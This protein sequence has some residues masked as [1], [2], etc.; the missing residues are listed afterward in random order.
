M[1]RRL[2]AICVRL[3][4]VNAELE[5][6]KGERD[7]LRLEKLERGAEARMAFEAEAERFAAALVNAGRAQPARQRQ[8]RELYF[9]DKELALEAASALEVRFEAGATAG[10]PQE[11]GRP[12]ETSALDREDPAVVAT[13]VEM[14]Y[15]EAAIERGYGLCETTGRI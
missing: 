11:L 8:W 12:R 7:D 5:S 3:E 1:E 10:E 13:L 6:V 4:A 9:K 2:D 15:D 14:G